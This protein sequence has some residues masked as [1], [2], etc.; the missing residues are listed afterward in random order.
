MEAVSLFMVL[1][2]TGCYIPHTFVSSTSA[3]HLPV[4]AFFVWRCCALSSALLLLEWRVY[5]CIFER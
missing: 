3:N 4:E 2:I 1:L 5:L